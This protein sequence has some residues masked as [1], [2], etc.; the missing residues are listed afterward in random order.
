M[1]SGHLPFDVSLGRPGPVVD[2]DRADRADRAARAAAVDPQLNIALQ[3]SAG[4]GKT[5]MLVDR[6]FNLLRAGVDPANILAITFTR[7]AAAE[8]RDRVVR[9]VRLA[10]ERG[11]I[12]SVRWSELRNRLDDIVIST[13]DA[14]CLSLLREFPLEADLDPGFRLADD[15]EVPRLMDEALDRTLRIGRARALE[16]EAVALV[17]RQLGDRRVR[18]GL[19][20]LLSRRLVAPA[21]LDQFLD[22]MEVTAEEASRGLV[23]D[24]RAAFKGVA[25]GLSAFVDDGPL[26]A[27]FSLL[28]M[29]LEECLGETT[30]VAAGA[31]PLPA[32]SASLRDYLLTQEGEPR[33]GGFSF[34]KAD[35]VTEHAF[36]HH[37]AMVV[38]LA[39]PVREALD[40]HRKVVNRLV[41]HGVRRLLQTAR[42]EYRRTLEAHAV[43]DFPDV[44]NRA[45]VLLRQ[46][47]EF[48]Q[49]RFRLEGRYHHILVDEFQDTS[50]AQW[51]LVS[52]LI[53]SWREG[54]GLAEAGPLAPSIFIVGDPK[55]S[56]Y[57]F[58]DADSGILHQAA[59][60]LEQLR[61]SGHVRHSISRSYRSAS[62]VL[63]FVND[64]CLEMVSSTAEPNRDTFR[65]D[66]EDRFPLDLSAVAES[67]PA[68]GLVAGD[69]P[70]ACAAEAAAEVLHLLHTATVRDRETGM[71]RSVTPGDVAILFRSRDSHR[72]F[73]S[74]LDAVGVR[75]YVYKGLG[76]FDAD[77]V[78]DVLALLWCLA[79]PHSNLRI[80]AW[81]R[82]RFVGIS[83]AALALLAPAIAEAVSS[84]NIEL[85]EGL[86]PIDLTLLG[87]ARRDLQ[88]WLA[89]VDV[90][91]P[92]ELVDLI[93]D[94]SAYHV[95]L[96]GPRLSQAREN[97][98]KLRSLIR[99]LQNRGHL[100]LARIVEYVDRLSIGDESNAVVD[101]IDAVNLMTIHAAKG[102]EFP[103]VFVVN[104]ARGT[105]NW[106]DPIRVSAGRTADD[107]VSVSVGT[108]QSDADEARP[109][110]ELEETKRLL[111]VALTRARDR[112][113]LG[114]VLKDGRMQP[115]R[116]SLG[117]VLP[118]AVQD[119][120]A[121]GGGGSG[122]PMDVEWRARSGF[123]HR[124]RV[125]PR[126]AEVPET[127]VRLP[128]CG[129]GEVESPSDYERLTAVP[130]ARPV[131]AEVDPIFIRQEQADSASSALIG[132]IAHRLIERRGLGEVGPDDVRELLPVLLS[133]DEIPADPDNMGHL[134]QSAAEACAGLARQR[135]LVALLASGVAYHEVPF[136]ARLDGVVR[137]GVLD[138]LVRS[139]DGRVTVVEFKTGRARPEHVTQLEV[140]RLA[141]ALMFPGSRVEAR[142]FYSG[143]LEG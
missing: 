116:G 81:L 6:I 55:Q 33:R 138:C 124:F 123:A 141:V 79:E 71:A 86:D 99:R 43:L 93:L 97:L 136:S 78:K 26:T 92:A 25:G 29:G 80:A 37:R 74:A 95:E 34:R 118:Q 112:L 75:T 128:G 142:V 143:A 22:G 14:F 100:T 45:L 103:I 19:A 135:D 52:L 98:K 11:E 3:A 30:T 59:G 107:L 134:V 101:A 67:E 83:D 88:R 28:R 110:Q 1:N 109:D 102:L 66:E 8:M 12:S 84:R 60:Y 130:F 64:L 63:A 104:L 113:Y 85:P 48:A 122:D 68:L 73:E 140:Y 39:P 57:G 32:L 44:L 61:P 72:V 36:R 65:Y 132:V 47:D 129:E 54:A 114:T 105:G 35:F 2:L 58:R 20:V 126:T 77:E 87:S 115:G 16:D 46:M 90:L 69:T 9:T 27:T 10:G 82:S 70:E 133:D 40:R 108:F 50:H 15:T 23:N 119:L 38:D 17:F 127:A 5:K 62:G 56:I 117:E 49:S 106:R 137:R 120:L 4:T 89:L 31:V 51:E 42:A 121:A 94:E 41:S 96:R 21:L 13:I 125:R 131:T 76:F 139:A 7:K 91:P 53:R 18:Q 111:Y 24:L